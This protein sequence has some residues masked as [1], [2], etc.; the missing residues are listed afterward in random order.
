MLVLARKKNERIRI[1]KDIILVVV[2]IEHGRVRLGI[3]APQ[4]YRILREELIDLKEGS[5]E[6]IVPFNQDDDEG[7]ALDEDFGDDTTIF[8]LADAE[9][10]SIKEKV[11]EPE[12]V[13]DFDLS[14][15][16]EP[17]KE[18]SGDFS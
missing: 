8:H 12:E 13:I 6:G 9:T 17:V 5:L 11:D 2:E 16:M 18:P 3:E 7:S 14:Q 4:S 15:L 10:E 1:G